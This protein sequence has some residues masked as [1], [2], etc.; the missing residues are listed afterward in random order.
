[1][2]FFEDIALALDAEGIESRATEAPDP[3]LFVPISADVEIQ[4]VETDPVLPAANV[5]VAAADVDEDDEDFD[6][7]LTSVVFSVEDAVATVAQ[8][9]ATD[10]LVS[11]LRELLEGS[12]SRLQDLQF[13][14]DPVVPSLVTAEVG[15]S[16]TLEVSVSTVDAAPVAR[17]RFICPAPVDADNLAQQCEE[18]DTDAV[19]EEVLELGTFKEINRLFDIV[20]FAA[21]QADSW[22]EQLVPVVDYEAYGD[23]YDHPAEALDDIDGVDDVEQF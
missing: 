2:S 20:A 10:Q 11:I 21:E 13:F 23:L 9:I 17:V 5:Y 15:D 3:T 1:M 18:C 7:V 6:A 4:F 16:S 8:H 22:E 12:D 19:A 14:Q